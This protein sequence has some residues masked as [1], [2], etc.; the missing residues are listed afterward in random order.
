[1]AI[2]IETPRLLIFP[3]TLPQ[4]EK[5]ISEPA[6]LEAELVLATSGA[7]LNAH[8][9]EAMAGLLELA[10][11]TRNSWPWMTNW[12]IV[13]KERNLGVGSACFMSVPDENGETEIGYG[14][15]P[16]FRKLGIMSE[17]LEALVKWALTSGGAGTV[18]AMTDPDNSASRRV[19]EKCGFIPCGSSRFV[20]TSTVNPLRAGAAAA[21]MLAAA[22]PEAAEHLKGFFKTGKGQYGEGDRFLGI[23]NPQTRLAAKE[24]RRLPL[25]EAELL[26]RNEFHEI[27]LCGLLI[28]TNH[29]LRG[30]DAARA[31]IFE[32][33]WQL[34]ASHVNNWDLVDLSAPDIAG[35]TALTHGPEVLE[36]FAASP[37]LWRQRIAVVGSIALIRSRRF[38]TTF[39]LAERFLNHRHDLMHKACGWML[40]E[41][42]KRDRAALTA[43]LAS[44]RTAMPRTMLRYAIEHYP[45]PERKALLAR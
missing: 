24:F 5:L 39:S 23:R 1:M 27:R 14:V 37:L 31:E 32:R 34:S 26:A 29:F 20:R 3:L 15:R 19:L 9:R 13:L 12:Q 40:R 6:A 42:G 8:T 44:H 11:K 7:E 38:D 16:E 22:S 30:G 45:E 41:I 35:E 25:A 33:Y 28:M 10:E 21:A 4:L 36:K 43:F 17:A 2:M 18:T